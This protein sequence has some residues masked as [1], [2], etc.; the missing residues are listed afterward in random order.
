MDRQAQT[1]KA[2]Q[3]TEGQVRDDPAARAL[4]QAVHARMYQWPAT[5][6]GYEA[7][8]QVNDE[9]HLFVGAV[10]VVPK[11][12][13]VVQLEA[14]EAL[15]TWVQERLSTQAMHLTDTPFEEGDGRYIVTFDHTAEATARHPRGVRVFLHGGRMASWYRIAE[16]RYI[17]ISRTIPD[18]HRQVNT[19]ERYDS[20][21]DG[22]LYASYY[23]MAYFRGPELTLAGME[24]YSNA[25][26]DVQGLLLPCQRVITAAE[27]GMVRTRVISLSA[28][29]LHGSELVHA[30]K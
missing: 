30:E 9:G 26:I 12:P 17:Q 3:T 5:F 20:A 25:F 4:L 8:L 29:R 16:E 15:R 13:V 22:R 21:P 7:A 14:D 28:H 18:Q 11:Q 1:E 27:H 24:S 10:T 23:V 6:A 19:I 2:L